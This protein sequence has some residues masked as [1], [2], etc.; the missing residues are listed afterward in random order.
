MSES[1]FLKKQIFSCPTGEEMLGCQY[2]THLSIGLFFE[3]EKQTG[4][5]SFC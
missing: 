5:D 4:K 3:E 1:S 2:N